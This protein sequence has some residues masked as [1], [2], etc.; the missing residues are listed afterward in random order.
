MQANVAAIRLGLSDAMMISQPLLLLPKQCAEGVGDPS[1]V[2][3]L[4]WRG[5]SPPG[6]LLAGVAIAAVLAGGVGRHQIVLLGF[7]LLL[8]PAD[9]ALPSKPPYSVQS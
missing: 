4:S 3:P 2:G 6:Q 9:A 5:C 1:K 7:G 8:E